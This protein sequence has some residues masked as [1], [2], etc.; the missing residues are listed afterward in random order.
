MRGDI[1]N[2]FRIIIAI[3]L[4][5][6][7]TRFGRSYWGYLIAIAWPLT[8]LVGLTIIFSVLRR[9]APIFGADNAIFISTG[10]LPYIL[11]IYPS[12]MTSFAFETNKSIFVFPAVKTLDLMISRAVIEFFSAVVVIG[13][14]ISG[15]LL[16]GVNILPRNIN[17][18]IFALLSTI[19]LAISLGMMSA[20]IISIMRF[21]HTAFA[22]ISILAYLTSGIFV[23]IDTLSQRAQSYLWYNPLAHC[24]EWLRSAYY[25]DYGD[26]F[27]S[28]EY[29][30]FLSTAIFLLS[31]VGEKYIRGRLLTQ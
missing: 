2:R 5:D 4:R 21:W 6:M 11:F 31:L 10:A 3:M 29:V 23:P 18:A 30:I 15:A 28:I 27:I 24:V 14:F 22:L 8:H 16:L 19:F 13:V 7:R 26:S 1:E 9:S 17:T 20:V 25:I 12:R